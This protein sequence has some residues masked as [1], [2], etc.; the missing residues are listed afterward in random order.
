MRKLPLLLFIIVLFSSCQ[1]IFREK[2]RGNGHIV[3]EQ[4]TIGDFSSIELRGGM[5]VHVKK[6]TTNLLKIETDDNLLP[7]IEVYTEGDKLIVREK[8]GYSL[9][10]TRDI[11]VYASAPVFRAITLSGAGD[12]LSDNTISG[13]ESLDVVLSGSGGM[14]L[15]VEVPK[16]TSHVSGSGD[17]SL[18]GE[19]TDADLSLSGS[20][21]VRCMDLVSDNVSLQ[22]SGSGDAGVTANKT[23]NVRISG[24]GSVAYRGNASVSQKISGSGEVKKVN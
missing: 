10:P 16:I 5:N 11:N 12:I 24:S 3:T 23:L 21:S 22:V 9:R 8:Q 7:Y 17:I 20:G 15:D 19:A 14:K 6:E 1:F 4:K 2:I 18:K 13:N